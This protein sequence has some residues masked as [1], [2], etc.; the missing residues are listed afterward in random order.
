MTI[1][2]QL[3]KARLFLGI[4]QEQMCAGVVSE[5]FYS[6]VENNKN[7]I[8]INDLLKILNNQHI[9]FYDFFMPFDSPSIDQEIQRAFINYNRIKLE[10]LKDD[11]RAQNSKYQLEFII[12]LAILDDHTDG[13]SAELKQKIKHRVLH[14]GEFDNDFLFELQ[15]IMPFCE[16]NEVKLLVD[17][18]LAS[19]QNL[20][21]VDARMPLLLSTLVAYIKRCVKEKNATEA[22]RIIKFIYNMPATSSVTIYRT[23]A[24][25]YSAL[26]DDDQAEVKKIKTLI[27]LTG[28]SAF[29]S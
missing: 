6:R 21:A 23:V 4:T 5:A 2:E 26:I 18:I 14:I 12:M 8:T 15:L 19:S 16:L 13:L 28:Y 24:R 20:E 17:Y 25:Y 3:K 29:I 27:Q 22:R 1:G 10:Q 9:S 11:P 7:D